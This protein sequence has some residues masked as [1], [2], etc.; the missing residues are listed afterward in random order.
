MLRK[1]YETEFKEK[2]V[3]MHLEDGRT[4]KSLNQEYNIGAGTLNNWIKL[5]REECKIN[6]I[7][8]EEKDYFKESK[9]LHKQIEELEKENRFLKKA[10]AFFAKEID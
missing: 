7:K 1:I 5:Y 8:Q 10:A 6:P 4:V 2:L 9:M 3:R